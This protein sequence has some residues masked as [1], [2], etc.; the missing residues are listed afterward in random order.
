MGYKCSSC[1]SAISDYSYICSGCGKVCKEKIV[2]MS[3]KNTVDVNKTPE[4][5]GRGSKKATPA[6]PV[7]LKPSGGAGKDKGGQNVIYSKS[8]MDNVTS[9]NK[10]D[11]NKK[12][13]FDF[14]PGMDRGSSMD[15][16]SKESMFDINELKLDEYKQKT[17]S[18]NQKE[19]HRQPQK[20]HGEEPQPP[21]GD[22][23]LSGMGYQ[24]GRISAK[25]AGR[26]KQPLAADGVLVNK[27]LAANSA[28]VSSSSMAQF[29]NL[30][31]PNHKLA[32]LT[33]SCPSMTAAAENAMGLNPGDAY[34]IKVL[35]S[36]TIE[37]LTS[38]V[39]RSLAVGVH[40]YGVEEII[41]LSH[42]DCVLK[43]LSTA[44]LIDAM[45]KNEIR[46]TDMDI[47][48]IKAFCGG[49]SN[50]KQNIR[51]TISFIQNSKLIPET[52]AIHG[53]MLAPKSYKLEVVVNGYSERIVV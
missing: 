8:A 21:D 18:H 53:M 26:E 13:D 11:V 7:I 46:R 1:G 4:T 33:C 10:I 16:G 38:E 52:V 31:T 40:L 15:I 41:V 34:V 43:Q 2:K 50:C 45:R 48:D 47:N 22:L 51:K 30:K 5:Q 28:F 20:H 39:M 25:A 3:G 49:F 44:K 36:S 37:N 14:T 19:S 6:E 12:S 9:Q 42:D 29:D 23:K 27:I 24:S 32:V 17:A 35:G